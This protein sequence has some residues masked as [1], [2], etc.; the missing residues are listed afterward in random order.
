MWGP[1]GPSGLALGRGARLGGRATLPPVPANPTQPRR[2]SRLGSGGLPL[3]PAA[4]P[5]G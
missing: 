5:P 2:S 1:R 4:T 3:S